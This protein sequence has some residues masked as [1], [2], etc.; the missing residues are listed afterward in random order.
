MSYSTAFS[1]LR[2]RPAMARVS[3]LLMGWICLIAC[4]GALYLPAL[5]YPFCSLDDDHYVTENQT[6]LGGLTSKGLMEAFG[7]GLWLYHPLT[8]MSLMGDV[9]LA[10]WLEQMQGGALQAAADRVVLRSVCR[11]HNILLHLLNTCLVGTLATRVLRSRG[12]GLAVAA[13]FG[14]HPLRVE[15]VVWIC[16]RKEL[17]AAAFGLLSVL[18]YIRW[19]ETGWRWTYVGSLTLAGCSLLAKPSWVMLPGLLLLIDVWPLGRIPFPLLTRN[20]RSSLGTAVVHVAHLAPFVALSLGCTA[21]TLYSIRDGLAT[22]HFLGIR[23]RL[24][25]VVVSYATYPLLDLAPA[26]LALLYP[27]RQTWNP[28]RVAASLAAV[29]GITA[30]LIRLR[31]R[32]PAALFGW[33]WYLLSALPTSGLVQNGQQAYADR[34]HYLP[35]IGLTITAV[36]MTSALGA[37]LRLPP[38]LGVVFSMAVVLCLAGLT[39]DQVRVWRTP[40]TLW[41]RSATAV[42][43]NW[44][45]LD[46]YAQQLRTQGRHAEAAACWERCFRGLAHRL[47]YACS[48]A[49]N[50][51]AAGR[52]DEAA[53]WRDAAMLEPRR[54]ARDWETVGRMEKAL[55]NRDMAAFAFRRA[56]EMAEPLG[57]GHGER[58]VRQSPSPV[59]ASH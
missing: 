23:S 20:G 55:G 59:S 26:N 27:L 31:G 50:A 41:H 51:A 22:T 56:A 42:S 32:C 5:S 45:A 54:T 16:E 40:E 53:L 8:L 39:H 30:V 19:A 35:G 14:L 37:W 24:E 44:Y 13:L 15:P 29:G 6:V 17:L 33:F 9:E 21:A 11:S 28:L 7:F 18:A 47:R 43:N 48:L 58:N 46:Q 3:G 57:V 4:T 36:G 34:F 52:P 49:E 25:T 1:A 2:R 10:G 12:A 38:R